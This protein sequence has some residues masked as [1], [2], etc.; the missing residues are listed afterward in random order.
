MKYIRIKSILCVALAISFLC[1]EAQNP[2]PEE[3]HVNSD[4]LATTQEETVQVAF[5]KVNQKDLLGGVSFV[6]VEELMKKNYI[7]YSLTDMEGYVGGWNGSTLWGIDGYLVLVDGIPRASNNVMSSEISQISFLKG[8]SAV[9]LYGSRAAK[10]V[11][12][13]T[14][15]RGK[16]GSTRIDVRGNTGF[17]VP[18]SYPKYL[19]SAEYMTLYNEARGN[20]GLDPAY[21]DNDIFNHGSGLNPYRYP[22]LNL[23][24]SD[25]LKKAYNES[26]ATAEISGGSD[27]ARFYTN[28]NLYNIGSLLKYGEADK[29]HITRFSV[30]GNIDVAIGQYV[31]TYVNANATFYDGQAA[32]GDFWGAAATL[33]P[34]RIS[35]LIPIDYLMENDENSWTLVNNSSNLIDDKYLLGGTQI[36]QQNALADLYASGVNTFT[37]RQYQ[38]DMGMDIDLQKVLKGLTFKAQFAVDYATTYNKYYGNSY[39][40]YEAR[41]ANMNGEDVIIGLSKYGEDR[42][43]GIQ[44]VSDSWNQQ[45]IAFSGQLNY[46]TK[47]ADTHKISAMLIAAGY[48]QGD[49]TYHRMSNVNLGLQLDYDYLSKYYVSLGGA[50]I[51]SAR[52]PEKNRNALSP[53]VTLG[54][55][56]DKESFLAESQALDELLLTASGS[57]LHTDLDITDYYMYQSTY[58]QSNGAWWG[59]ADGNQSRASESRRGENLD[60]T[61]IKRKEISVGLRGSLWNKLLAFDASFFTNSLEGLP[62]QSTTIY[63]NYFLSYWPESTLIPYVNYNNNSRTG[64]D[65]ALNYNKKVGDIDLGLGVSGTYYT[66]QHNRLDEKYADEYRYRKGHPTDGMWGLQTNGFYRDEAD[67]ASSPSSSFGEVQPGDIKYIDQNKDGIIDEKDEVYLNARYGWQGAPFTMGVNLTLKWKG[68][69]F[70]ALGTGYY[71]ASAMKNSNYYWVYGDRKYSEIVRN[72]WTPETAN[73]ATYPR[74]TTLS[75]THNFLNSDFWL[76]KTDRFK[77]AKVQLTYDFP[78]SLFQGSFIHN[79]SAYVYA[80]NLLTIA[81]ERKILELNTGT[82]PENRFYNIGFKIGF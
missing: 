25:Y 4:S 43:D 66:N 82:A 17:H 67:V 64:F 26:D 77:L 28:I 16:E 60:L 57:I 19:G 36:D 81:K 1:A 52:L 58:N 51:H 24:S 48:Q 8:A 62:V 42:K 10:G 23:Y 22:D 12:Y 14:T 31:K 32:R 21:S 29:D 27:K 34:N 44:H 76:C 37:S 49:S 71:G 5:R 65:F 80:T 7:N 68:L 56:I 47:V 39:A 33:R 41:W 53:S 9:V 74:L 2:Q 78:K 38:F 45:T 6:N 20:D 59:W 50:L 46:N 73:T 13:I 18:V 69:T 79:L 63:P 75:N 61:F 55:R 70:F 72:R 3:Q 40:T 35:P 15:K 30:R 11:V 54:W